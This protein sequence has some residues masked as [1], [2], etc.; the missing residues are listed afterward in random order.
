MK[1]R[2]FIRAF[3]FFAAFFFIAISGFS[4]ANAQS[5]A[6][7]DIVNSVPSNLPLEIELLPPS[8]VGDYP[9]KIRIKVTNTG[10][11]P[12]YSLRLRLLIV[13]DEVILAPNGRRTW[14]TIPLTYGR[15]ELNTG[16]GESPTE[17]DPAIQPSSFHIFNVNSYYQKIYS[18]R[19]KAATFIQPS[20]YRLEFSDLSFGDGTGF[21]RGGVPISKKNKNFRVTNRKGV[22]LYVCST[23]FNH[24]YSL[25]PY[26]R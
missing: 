3:V 18:Q 4:E 12:I 23:Q 15:R 1:L 9:E 22:I 13:T 2:R 20:S 19:K 21:T 26:D 11:R 8:K 16:I 7:V 6:K 5:I 10:N 24:P 17:N 25:R 14:E